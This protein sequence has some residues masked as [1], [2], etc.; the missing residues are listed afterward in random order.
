MEFAEI[1]AFFGYLVY[2]E[3]LELKFC[4]LDKDLKR[5][6]IKRNDLETNKTLNELQLISDDSSYNSKDMNDSFASNED[7]TF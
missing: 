4:G 7:Y 1:F 2:L 5:K 3:I 6:I